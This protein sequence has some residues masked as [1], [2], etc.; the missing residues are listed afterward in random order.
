[1]PLEFEISTL[2]GNVSRTAVLSYLTDHSNKT[3]GPVYSYIYIQLYRYFNTARAMGLL[4]QL[5]IVHW[6]RWRSFGMSHSRTCVMEWILSVQCLVMEMREGMQ[7][8]R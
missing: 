6:L 5:A 7:D 1:M 8:T 3:L 4:F 2:I